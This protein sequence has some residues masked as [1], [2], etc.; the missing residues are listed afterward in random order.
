MKKQGFPK[1][2]VVLARVIGRRGG[3]R[4]EGGR[5][6]EVRQDAVTIAF[7]TV[8]YTFPIIAI[9][10]GRKL[11]RQREPAARSYVRRGEAR[12]PQGF[13]GTRTCNRQTRGSPAG[14]CAGE[15]SPSGCRNHCFFHCFLHFSYNH[16][17]FA[18]EGFLI[19]MMCLTKMQ[20]FL[21]FSA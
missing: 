15:G 11:L 5:A 10:C 13:C 20:G 3:A 9:Y 18:G 4:L 8:S 1:V 2:S 6:K 21:R 7:S 17:F 16:V 19:P 12:F 14:R